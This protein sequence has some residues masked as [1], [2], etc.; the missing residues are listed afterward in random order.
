MPTLHCYRNA[1]LVGSRASP[2][3]SGASVASLPATAR[4]TVGTEVTRCS[5]GPDVPPSSSPPAAAL[6]V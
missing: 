4:P 5:S 1:R 2:A 6:P 3:P